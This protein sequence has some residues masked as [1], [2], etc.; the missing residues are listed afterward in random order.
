MSDPVE[1]APALWRFGDPSGT[2]PTALVLATSDGAIVIDPPTESGGRGISTWCRAHAGVEVRTVI[3][4]H[5]HFDHIGGGGVLAENG[6]EVITH[7]NAIEPITGEGLP[8]A[9]PTRT[10]DSELVLTLGGEEIRLSHVAPSHSNSM[11]VI[12]FAR[13]R[14]LRATDFCPI[15]RVPFGDFADFYYDGWMRSLEWVAS[16]APGL[17]DGGHGHLGT[18]AD[19]DVQ[20]SYMGNLHAEVL[21]LVRAGQPWDELYRNVEFDPVHRQLQGFE[22]MRFANILGMHRWV[23]QHRRGRY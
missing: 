19:V 4:S 5:A 13:Q 22:V 1:I 12:E 10:F 18:V 6:A 23:A 3:Y 8:T 20:L 17:V 9:L 15:R 21:R 11:I 14:T 7:V 16:R 2:G